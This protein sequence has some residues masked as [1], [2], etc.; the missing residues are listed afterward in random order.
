MYKE[1]VVLLNDKIIKQ[2]SKRIIKKSIKINLKLKSKAKNGYKFF[3]IKNKFIILTALITLIISL[4][5]IFKKYTNKNFH[6]IPIAFSFN[7]RYAY[8]IIVLLISILYNAS[9]KTFYTF[10]LLIAPDIQ[11]TSLKKILGLK[12]K[13]PNCKMEFINMGNKYSNY[14][15]MNYKSPAVYYRLELSNIIKNEEKIIYLDVDTMVHKD[16]TDMYNIDMGKNYYMG[17]PDRDL[18]IRKFHG[19]RNFINSL[20]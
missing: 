19:T 13:Y 20:I 16:L 12:E 15:T 1:K 3:L 4:I 11:K 8:P 2:K 17:F 18:A 10:Y 9:P 7:D 14:Y 5:L 6:N